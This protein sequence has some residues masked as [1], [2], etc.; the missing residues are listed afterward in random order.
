MV[1][2]RE[3]MTRAADLLGWPP[4][5]RCT[6]TSSAKLS[7]PKVSAALNRRFIEPQTADTLA[8]LRAA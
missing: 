2:L 8:R 7:T 3:V 5:G 4:G 1:D 6:K